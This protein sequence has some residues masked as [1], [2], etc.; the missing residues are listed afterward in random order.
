MDGD[1]AMMSQNYPLQDPECRKLSLAQPGEQTFF[2][3]LRTP[4]W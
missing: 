4:N 3:A 1:E 2:M